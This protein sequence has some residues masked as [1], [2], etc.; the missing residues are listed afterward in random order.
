MDLQQ[1]LKQLEAVHDWQGV[2]EELER[3]IATE[4]QPSNKAHLH[5]QIGRLLDEKFLQSVKALKHFQDAFKL[6][7]ALVEALAD[8]RRIYWRL[9][10]L[11]MVQKLLD[12]ELKVE[13]EPAHV[14]ALLLEMGDVLSDEGDFERAMSTYARALGASKGNNAEASACLE[15]VQI[16][17]GGWQDRVAF[18]LRAAHQEPELRAK[19]R[20]FLRAARIAKRFAPEESEGM[21]TQAFRADPTNI[22]VL[23]LLEA[24]LVDAGRTE[25]IA[26]LQRT[27][28]DETEDGA[29]RGSLAFVFG[30]RWATRHQNLDLGAQLAEEA[31]RFDPDNEAAF[32]F[33][34]EVYGTRDGAWDRVVQIA[35]GAYDR[36]QPSGSRMFLLSQL[37]LVYWQKLGNMLEAQRAFERLASLSAAHP[38]LVAF[39]AQIG[40]KLKPLSVGQPVDVSPVPPLVEVSA[41]AGEAEVEIGEAEVE[42]GEAEVEVG[43]AEVEVGEAEVEV[44]EAEVEVGEAEVEVGEAVSD[45]AG[46]QG[47]AMAGEDA[48]KIAELRQAAVTQEGSKRFNELV[49]TLMSLADLVPNVSEKIDL[50]QRAADLFVTKFANQAEAIKAYEKVVEYDPGNRQAVDYL[51]QMYEKRR[52]WE[53][54][55]RLRQSEAKALPPDRRVAELV[56]IADVATKRLRKPD[57]CIDLWNA[58]L[59]ADPDN[60]QALEAVAP[61]L[62]HARRFEELVRVLEKQV[63]TTYEEKAKILL[64]T[65]LGTIYG[66]RLQNE[67][68]AVEAWRLLL[69]LQPNDRRAQEQLRKKYITLRRWD[70]LELFYSESGKWDEFIR[71][72]ESE[73]SKEADPEGKI[74]L[75]MKVAQLWNDQK[76]K[77]D[78][79]ARALEKVLS[80]DENHLA[81][82]EALIPIYQEADNAKGLAKAIEVKLSHEED[83]FTKLELLREVAQLYEGKVRDAERAF[84]RYLSAFEISPGDEA[85]REDVERL[86]KT[87]GTWD[88]VIASYRRAIETAEREG[89]QELSVSLHLKLG[90]VLVDEVNNVDQA[91][92]EFRSVY[93]VDGENAEAIVALE[94][95]YRQT[96]RFDDL[97]GIYEKKRD[98]TEDFDQKREV[99]YA[100]AGLYESEMRQP[101]R[102]IETYVAV[103]EE[104]PTDVQALKALD[105]L[106]RAQGDYSSYA[107]VLRRLIE[108]DVTEAELIDLK[109][110]LGS[111]LEQHLSDSLGALQN[112]R[113]ILFVDQNHDGAR[114]ALESMLSNEDLAAEAAQILDPIY[115]AREDWERLLG[116]LEVLASGQDDVVSRVDILRRISRTA[117]GQLND[118]ERAFAAQARALKEDPANVEARREL[119]VLAEESSA[120]TKLEA[121]FSEIAT[122][123]T[124]VDL[125]RDYWMRLAAIEERL[126]KI[127]AA[128]AGYGHVL[129]L[130]PADQEALAAL[131]ALYR[132]TERWE[133]LIGVFRKRIELME[134]LVDRERLYAQMAQV[135]ETRL[136]RPED[137]I[138]AYQEVLALDETSQVALVA[139]DALF[140]RQQMWL[141]LA[142]NLEAQLRLAESDEDERTLM[143]RLGAL[144]ESK[145]SQV[146]QAVDIYRQVLDRDMG[147]EQALH[148][149]ERLGSMPD[150][151]LTIAE[152]LE[153]LYRQVGDFAKL[154]G[155]HEVQVR[156]T[157]DPVRR[158][159]LL[160]Q[161][162]SLYEDAAG[163]LHA[164]FDTLARA[165]AEDPA[166]ESTQAALERLARATSRF[167]DLARVYETLAGGQEDAFLASQLYSIAARVFEQ[168]LGD[169]DNAV[170]HYR[171]VLSIDPTNLSAAEALEGLFRGAER[172]ADLSAV[173]QTKAEIVDDPV[174]KK[175]ALFQAAAIEEEMLERPEEAI[176]VY[177]RALETDPDDLQAVD[178]LIGQYLGLKRWEDLLGVYTKKVDLV[179]DPEEKKLIY[180]QMGAVYEREL[181]DVARAI[182]TY[183]RVLELDPDDLQALGRLDVLYQTSGAWA[184]LLTVLQHESELTMDAAEAISYQ[185]RIAELYEKHLEDV[186]RAIELYRDILMQQADHEPTLQALERLKDGDQEPLAAASVLEPFYD[187][188]A[189]WPKLISVLEVQVRF[190]DDPFMQ[191]DLLH[192]I[193]ALYEDNLQDHRS[194]FDTYARALS[195]DNTNQDTLAALER[196]AAV[197]DRWA[198]TAGL[199]DRELDRLG[200]NPDWFVEFGLRTAAIYETQLE[201]LDS[202]V[203]RFRKVLGVAPEN[204]QA[205]S[206]LD[207]LFEM[208]ERWGDLAQVL[209]REAEV[210]ADPDRVLDFRFRLGQVYQH[211]LDDIDQAVASYREVI[212]AMPEHEHALEALELL[213]GKGIK[214]AEI[215]EVLEPLYTD[216]AQWEK[217]AGVHEA[218]LAHQ[219]EPHDRLAMYFRIAEDYEHNLLDPVRA[220]DVFVRAIKEFPQDERVG[221]DIERLAADTDGGWDRLGNAYADVLDVQQ[222]PGVQKAIGKRHARVF[223][224]ELQQIDNAVATYRYVLGVDPADV[225]ALTNLDRIFEAMEQ[226]A[227]LAQV[228][229]QRLKPTDE[230]VDLVELHGRLGAVYEERLQQYDDAIRVYRRIFD[231]LD[232]SHEEAISALE[233]LYEYKE[234][235]AELNVVYE[236]QLDNAMGDAEEADIRAKM[237]RLAAERLGDIDASIDTWK[238]VLDLRGEDVEALGA[239]ANLYEGR[240]QWAELCD[241][242]ERQFDIAESDEA[243]VSIRLRRA[244]VFLV[245]LNRDEEAIDD[246]QRVLDID[247]A[248]VDALRAIANIWRARNDAYEL[249]QAL[250]NLVERASA[251]LEAPE[252]K[253]IFRELGVTYGTVLVQPFDA[254]EAW[255]RLL[256]VDPGDFEA[257]D[258][259]EAIYRQDERYTDVV[260]VKMRRAEALSEP[261]EKTRE[262]L[263]VTRIWEERVGDRDAGTMAFERVLGIDPTH[264]EAFLAL[265]SLHSAAE[266]WEPLIELYL[267]RLETREAIADRTQLL[268]KI[269]GVF[270]ERVDDK[271]QAFDA[272]LQAFE[273]D[274]GDNETSRYLEKMAQATNRW[275]ELIQT[276]NTWL[277]GEQ[278]KQDNTK[279]IQLCLRLAKWY[280]ED[281]G[282]AQY[283]QPYFQ[284]VMQLDPTN[285]AV[286][287]QMGNLY[288]KNQQWQELGRTLTE[289][290]KHATSEKDRK[291]IQTELGELL[292]KQ[293]NEI[294]KGMMFYKN[295]LEVDPYHLP[296]LEALERIYAEREQ[297]RDLVDILTAKVVSK[298]EEPEEVAAI[299]VRVGGLFETT[300]NDLE[301]ATKAYEA[302]LDAEPSNL[303]AMRGLERIFGTQGNWTEMVKVL[304]QQLDVVPT[305]RERI[306]VLM[307]LALIYEE[308]FLKSDE[309]AARFEQVLDVDPGQEPALVGLERC[310]AKLRQW[311]DLVSTYERHIS[312]TLDRGLKVELFGYVAQVFADEVQDVDRA[313]DAYQSI[314]DLDDTNIGA[315]EALAKLYERKDSAAD[316]IDYMTRVA[317][318]TA[319]GAQRV[320]M[321][322]RIGH[323]LDTQLGDRVAARERYEMALDLDPAHLATLA[324]LKD[325]AIDAAEYDQAARYLD[326]EQMHTQSARSRAKLLVELGN[327]R[328]EHLE[329][330]DLAVQA[331]ELALQADPESEEAA[332][333]LLEEYVRVGRWEEADPLA[334]MLLKKGASKLER[335]ELHHLY[336]MQGK[337]ASELGNNEKALKSYKEAHHLDLTDQETIR[338]LA[339]VSFKMG[340]WASALSNYQKVLTALEE[341]DREERAN[342]YFKLGCIK[343]EQG[344]L[345]QAVNN[346][347]KALA[348]DDAHRV[349]LEAMVSIYAGLSDWKQVC[350]YKRQILDNVFEADERFLMLND[351]GD[352]WAEKE[353]NLPKAIETL[354]EAL[355]LKPDNHVL[356]HKLLGL[357]QRTR[358]YERMIDT[359]QAISE[360]EPNPERKARYLYTM[361][362]LYRDQNDM[363]RA[364]ELFNE[365]LD[366]NPDFLESF[367]R[368]N[369]ILTTQK[370]WKQLERAFRKMIHRIAGKGKVDLEYNLWH[371]LGIVYRDRLSDVEKSIEAFRMASRIKPDDITERQ[372]LAELYETANQLDLAVEEQQE[373]L[374]R[375]P[376]QVAPYRALYQLYYQK[377][378]YD[379]AW[380]MCGALSFLRRA[381]EDQQKFYE[382][383]RPKG[384][385]QVRSR[386]DNDSWRKHVYHRTEDQTIGLIFEML[387]SAAL[388]AKMQQLKAA[389]QLPVLDKRYKQEPHTT[390]V[391]FAKTFFHVAKV[392]GITPPELYVHTNIQGGLTAAP[393]MPFASVA[394]QSVLSGF[395]PHELSFIVAKHLSN[396]RGEHY[397]KNIFPTQSELTQLF[398]AGLRMVLPD[399][400]V[401]PEMVQNVDVTAK[402]LATMMQPQ[403]REGLRHVVRKF[404]DTKGAIN[405]KRWLQATDLTA[406]RAGLLVCGDLEIAKKIL[407]IEPQVPGDLTPED[408]I[409]EMIVFSV[410]N[411]YFALRK[412]LGLTIG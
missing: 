225:D 397:I 222:D 198:Q 155:V 46:M 24:L 30:L 372:I 154:I 251:V 208:T 42:V 87:I 72:L 162:A 109:Y 394:G 301:R 219:R 143:L 286:L 241:V 116:V 122:S 153:P 175:A 391:T 179:F 59:E 196:L 247:Y 347:E 166:H 322:Y 378:A 64:L 190:Q 265:E 237:A 368:I 83:D 138:A 213:F 79:A 351:V 374:R 29:W 296:A 240:G 271:N 275:S 388:T 40:Q 309:A 334:D 398:F 128:A 156:R 389:N 344:Q 100:I 206:S 297:Y 117:A 266:R 45:A 25:E 233:R 48:D 305:E 409:T 243:R 124:D 37:G 181:G 211:R 157:D 200:D 112:Y 158:V 267:S 345:K 71:V 51:L 15:D 160:H 185:Y 169:V 235:W 411:E 320:E 133:D 281:L 52:D 377:Q 108:L 6:Q 263:E 232:P 145:M 17:T 317:E 203:A 85:C 53:N 326:Q 285:V 399:A 224:E 337:V 402:T 329:E 16:E 327:L 170:K 151:E 168:D 165:L 339:E 65:K 209:V 282:H 239:L 67:E 91:L 23:T 328:E 253:A 96:S 303:L 144:R 180:Y 2:L 8:A 78:R 4:S 361:A 50:Y 61:L 215:A 19:A 26:S 18:L 254:A 273:E 335:Y 164:A 229:E 352:I 333:P 167:A 14:S 405:L 177:L 250:H 146:E 75:L 201:D 292:E 82:A 385:P 20:L 119:E 406:C 73:E 383:Y 35:N 270:E 382:D 192:R 183:Q 379:E 221:E 163:D 132:R 234:A 39:E 194:A 306:E 43:E 238:R 54:L 319:D 204:E 34:R 357:Y 191:V 114:N 57:I 355:E 28:L 106:Y 172:F 321:Y 130:D 62:E 110:R 325:I 66:D 134:D 245:R 362:Q 202:A 90:R 212:T 330:H 137:A 269:A 298:Q 173:L 393:I 226:W 159:E 63:E 312:V 149:L 401:P 199:Y 396:Y 288:R 89:E 276:A 284:K 174:E 68:G 171:K 350:A 10:K 370:D 252:L 69:A 104:D 404:M 205:L 231:E 217:L 384:I 323:S 259:L 74:S 27:L 262:L 311:L 338:G 230:P 304:E 150:Y 9:G 113:E 410:S 291:E 228:L 400:P 86:A 343:R 81:A 349:T 274:Y 386:L 107:D 314:V 366:L 242:L 403:H 300:L 56:D 356:L 373:I 387:T 70:D 125:A 363:G 41:T 92:L 31:L 13:G 93:D 293:L 99:L 184:E 207:R 111:T 187:G 152:I 324:A 195:L 47:E 186:P 407:L 140:T 295:A 88:S 289:A 148:A 118:L 123:L 412:A 77:P 336:A 369:K 358:N 371:N 290:L 120:W 103:L 80:I 220:M 33:L 332:R 341:G 197:T 11:N 279:V 248:N 392:L 257:L 98:L 258:A 12:L 36:A 283:A 244:H 22:Q 97:L 261:E 375:D 264:D 60:Q 121:I 307:K 380:C 256:E 178:A 223:E 1:R 129:S 188:A 315:L 49:R 348:I 272:L 182:D 142:D 32:L 318:L 408:K 84:E 135:Y 280:G 210:T 316:A 360:L 331:Y 76:G 131:D 227:E 139:L 346:F 105:A 313:I 255:T 299:Q 141:E 376:T 395:T 214:Q 58:V 287:R 44:G 381:D 365:A 38:S 390:T 7:P 136:G 176:K 354:E 268:R 127:D 189:Q 218:Q 353:N 249:V 342:V 302:A 364:V 278:E 294:E 308:Q 101:E 94:S 55:I 260:D 216:N 310:Y 21:L 277:Q 193:A 126:D 246:Y 340:D 236:R 5:L 359:I 147:N 95:L 102:A 367:E 3:A 161:I 115:E